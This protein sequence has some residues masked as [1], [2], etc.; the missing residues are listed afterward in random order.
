M[1]DEVVTAHSFAENDTGDFVTKHY[2][3]LIDWNGVTVNGM[4]QLKT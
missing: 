2:Y 4:F 1:T 3:V